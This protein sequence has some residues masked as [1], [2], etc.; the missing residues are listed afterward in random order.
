VVC[1]ALLP[2]RRSRS[3]RSRSASALV[4]GLAASALLTRLVAG[5]LFEVRPT[6]PTTF[7]LIPVLL[8]ATAA[9]AVWRPARRAAAV[10][11]ETALR[12]E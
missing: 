12:A 4:A 9:F 11:P 2:S 1:C 7:T 10:D 3:R 8:A 6:D 5:L